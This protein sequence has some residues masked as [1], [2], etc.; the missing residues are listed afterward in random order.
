M[1]ARLPGSL[2]SGGD[3]NVSSSMVQHRRRYDAGMSG[4]CGVKRCVDEVAKRW[5][6]MV[7]MAVRAQ[8]G[9][10]ALYWPSGRTSG[11]SSG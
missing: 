8:N 5:K 3:E 1:E 10:E 7:M 2:G 11:R 4:L 9:G 6:T